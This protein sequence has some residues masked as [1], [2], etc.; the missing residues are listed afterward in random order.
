MAL[1]QPFKA[2]CLT[3]WRLWRVSVNILALIFF[4]GL[5]LS[6]HAPRSQVSQKSS[7]SSY[8]PRLG[9][10]TPF[11]GEDFWT[12]KSSNE[13]DSLQKSSLC[14]RRNFEIGV[15]SP[16]FFTVTLGKGDKGENHSQNSETVRKKKMGNKPKFACRWDWMLVSE[17]VTDSLL[18]G[19][20]TP[21]DSIEFI[22]TS[23]VTVTNTVNAFNGVN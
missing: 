9:V 11:M 6:T 17:I 2:N 4:F 15:L 3:T 7:K 12:R 8:P 10:M 23:C 21:A 20:V 19:S 5:H 13:N 22:C 14:E 16:T 18:L 1:Y